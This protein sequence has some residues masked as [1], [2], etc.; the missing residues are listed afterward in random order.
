[1]RMKKGKGDMA[2]SADLKRRLS[3]F[4][5]IIFPLILLPLGLSLYFG[6]PYFTVFIAV[7]SLFMNW[8]WEKMVHKRYSF[9]GDVH[10]AFLIFV[11]FMSTLSF[12]SAFVSLGIV[13]FIA[14]GLHFFV[15]LEA[16]SRRVVNT[17]RIHRV[18]FSKKRTQKID[19]AIKSQ[20]DDVRMSQDDGRWFLHAFGLLYIGIPLLCFLYLFDKGGWL[21]I[22]WILAVVIATDVGAYVFGRRFGGLKI[23]PHISS[24][25]TWS[26][27]I[28]GMICAGLV[29]SILA[30]VGFSAFFFGLYAAGLAI[31]AQ[32]GDFFESWIKRVTGVKD[33]S[34]IIPGH[35]GILDRI[36]GLMFVIVVVALIV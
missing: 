29:G 18:F 12:E 4:F 30:G 7:A 16:R 6:P 15:I 13:F 34:H 25:K 17:S 9:M 31:V 27:L 23:A 8:E 24:G 33:S 3:S 11:F 5:V 21:G 10:A 2:M 14:L 32:A 22:I 20:D 28:G 36:D 1:M 19:P 35:G 26:G